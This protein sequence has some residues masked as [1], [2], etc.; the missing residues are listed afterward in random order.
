MPAKPG[1]ISACEDTQSISR[2]R[3]HPTNP[4]IVY[5]AALGHPYGASD[6]RGIFRT[7]DG[8]QTWKR[9]LFRNNKAGAVDLCMDPQN[10]KVLFAAIWD[11]YRTPWSL[12]SGGPASG[13][14]KTTDGGDTWT[15]ITRNPGLPA[16]I[17][18]KIGVSVSGADSNR[19]YAIVEAEDGGVYRS[20]DAGANWTK[21]SEDRKLRQRAFY[22]SRIYSDPKAKDTL[23]ICNVGFFKSTDAGKTYTT[24]R[25]PH[26][27]NHDLWIDPANPQRMVQS[28]DG[29]ANVSNN[30]GATWS[31]QNYP[32]AQLYHVSTTRDVPYH[33][34]GAQQDNTTLCVPSDTGVNFRD[35]RATPG[36]WLY[37][38]GGGESG[39]IAPH[40]TDPDHLL[41]RQPGCLA[42]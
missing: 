9:I 16:N 26:G 25:P 2:I 31:G 28:N 21:V 14:F 17:I 33:V 39:Y 10:P 5:V 22:Y 35:P 11:V 38:V 15:E 27:D 19:I 18:G 40:P 41:R 12:S 36:S 29:G 23:Y 8:G 20:D 4:D 42:D 34:C 3:I 13:L 37:A 24:I 30:G 6:D 1:S 7:T 32:T